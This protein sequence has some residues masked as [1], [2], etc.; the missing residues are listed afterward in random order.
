MPAR[1]ELTGMSFGRLLAKERRSYRKTH[2]FWLCECECGTVKEIA[3]TSLLRGSTVSCG[4]HRREIA[5]KQLTKHSMCRSP[6][7][8][9]RAHL[10]D[11]C[12]NQNDPMSPHYGGRGI[13]VCDKWRSSFE[14]FLADMG[15]RPSP[16]HSIDRIDNDGNY[17]PG[18]CRWATLI[19]QARN[20]SVAKTIEWQGAVRKYRDVCDELGIRDSTVRSRLKRGWSLER[21][22]LEPVA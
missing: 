9:A 12:Y 22:L 10:L 18:N 20:T 14:C 2:S 19:E 4:C 21:A 7:Y 15:V 1:K 16:G 6:E 5:R 3:Q 13:K 11:R 17:E 8:R